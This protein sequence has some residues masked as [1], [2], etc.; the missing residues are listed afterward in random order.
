LVPWKIVDQ[1]EQ[2]WL[3]FFLERIHDPLQDL[4]SAK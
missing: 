2:R 4:T 1:E 3:V